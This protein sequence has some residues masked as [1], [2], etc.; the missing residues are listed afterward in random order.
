MEDQKEKK[1]NE[2]GKHI[3]LNE[4]IDIPEEGDVIAVF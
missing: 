1:L 3:K 2:L 4:V